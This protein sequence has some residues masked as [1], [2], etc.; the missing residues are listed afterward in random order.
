MKEI[1]RKR[2]LLTSSK[3]NN[4]DSLQQSVEVSHH[5]HAEAGVTNSIPEVIPD[6][7]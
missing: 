5:E 7:L 6:T 3:N 1:D 2:S 4:E